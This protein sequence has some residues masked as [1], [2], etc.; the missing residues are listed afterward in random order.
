M[1]LF[2]L[3]VFIAFAS[4]IF[5]Q[6]GG[7]ISI[8]SNHSYSISDDT[9]TVYQ[10]TYFTMGDGALCPTLTYYDFQISGNE[11]IF[12]LYYDISDPYPLLS[13]VQ[14]D[15][16]IEE[17]GNGTYNLIV[18]CYSFYPGNTTWNDSDTSYNL[19]LELDEINSQKL[20]V[21]PNPSTGVIFVRS[22]FSLFNSKYVV[23]DIVGNIKNQGV[24]HF[25]N[26][27]SLTLNLSPG[28]Y[29]LHVI[30]A[31]GL[32]SRKILIIT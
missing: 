22:D 2:N 4:P 9:L 20:S 25:E 7:A 30:D 6:T 19:T 5:S 16:L 10:N 18:N 31:V 14:K 27:G 21:F 23:Y 11:I 13:C 29:V 1:K 15:T 26:K 12:D 24:I 3:I 28:Q 32:I 8:F 17:I